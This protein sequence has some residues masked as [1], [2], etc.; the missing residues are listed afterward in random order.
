MYSDKLRREFSDRPAQR[1]WFARSS[2][3]NRLY[4]A[5]MLQDSAIM[6]FALAMVLYFRYEQMP[7]AHWLGVLS[8]LVIFFVASAFALGAY[9][10][11]ALRSPESAAAKTFGAT[12]A[13]YLLIA[14]IFYLLKTGQNYSRAVIAISFVTSCV[15]VPLTR[16]FLGPVYL[17][18]LGGRVTH[19]ILLVEEEEY[20]KLFNGLTPANS[21][22]F[23]LGANQL[24]PLQDSLASQLQLSQIIQG[25]DRVIVACARENELRWVTFLQSS[26]ACG[27]IVIA[28]TDVHTPIAIGRFMGQGTQVV[29]KGALT[30]RQKILKRTFDLTVAVCATL[31]FL[32]LM[33][34]I[35]LLI[36][37]DSDGPVLFRQERL[38]KGNVPFRITKFRT[39]E[40]RKADELGI[41]SASRGDPRVT[42]VGRWLRMTSL[43]ELPQLFNVIAGQMSIVGPRPHA[44]GSTAGDKLFWHVDGNYWN[45][46]VLQPGI[47][48]LAQI[49]GFRGATNNSDELKWRLRSDL[50]YIANWSLWSD[51]RILFQ[52]LKVMV[53]P[54]AY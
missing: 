32:P 26:D 20:L 47:T 42:C 27:E 25:A 49:R 10:V 18:I 16:I 28:D 22:V 41:T 29:N 45:R 8:I 52:T 12:I 5:L 23:N 14:L 3:R 50:E 9:S 54:N 44:L 4:A 7:M 1:N 36:K 19:D 15:A 43:D 37:L 35:S 17:W 51:I 24:Q 53:H 6:A 48:G 39:M 40:N 33:L 38:G 13:A 34:L 46:H 31:F 2:I 30:M 21:Q 11:S